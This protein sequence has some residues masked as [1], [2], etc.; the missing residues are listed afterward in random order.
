MQIAVGDKVFV[1]EW[2]EEV[3]VKDIDNQGNVAIDS[4]NYDGYYW[5]MPGEYEDL[6]PK[7]YVTCTTCHLEKE[8]GK[9]CG[10]PCA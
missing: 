9:P 5:L 6:V 2:N 10:L 8:K 7:E 3:E 1:A 4:I